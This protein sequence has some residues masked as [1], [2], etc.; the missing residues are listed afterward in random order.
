VLN[1]LLSDDL[2][3]DLTLYQYSVESL[4]LYSQTMTTL[5]SL[6]AFSQNLFLWI[7]SQTAEGSF[8]T[9][10]ST[11]AIQSG[12]DYL[13]QI[14]KV[15]LNYGFDDTL[16]LDLDYQFVHQSLPPIL[17]E[18]WE[19]LIFLRKTPL[20]IPEPNGGVIDQ[21]VKEFLEAIPLTS[22][23]EDL[24]VQQFKLLGSLPSPGGYNQLLILL[25]ISLINRAYI[26]LYNYRQPSLVYQTFRPTEVNRDLNLIYLSGY[27]LKKSN[28]LHW[29]ILGSNLITL[30]QRT[31]DTPATVKTLL[32]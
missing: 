8:P 5:K 11:G 19:R 17:P 24:Q 9:R 4:T 10:P 6:G 28:L 22:K 25:A 16:A 12:Y 31:D 30:A 7:R 18:I 20:Y 21:L 14:A 23:E 3:A 29:I 15:F 2:E 32:K 13:I 1:D 26:L 27:L